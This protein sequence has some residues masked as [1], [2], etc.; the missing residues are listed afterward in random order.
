MF[1][2]LVLDCS[3]SC[4]DCF[5]ASSCCRTWCLAPV[6]LGYCVD[7]DDSHGSCL[8][9]DMHIDICLLLDDVT[10]FYHMTLFVQCLSRLWDA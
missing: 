4:S 8:C 3:D 9:C 5:V 7:S 10:D 2:Y 6:L 1:D